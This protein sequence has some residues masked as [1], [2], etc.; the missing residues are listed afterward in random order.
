MERGR[1]V[2]DWMRDWEIILIFIIKFIKKD[3][4]YYA[5]TGENY[6]GTNYSSSFL[7]YILVY[8]LISGISN[9]FSII[10]FSSIQL[11][12]VPRNIVA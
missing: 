8:F 1:F 6:V 9:Q 7:C 11:K 3:V 5:P 10:V 12:I 4:K 2:C